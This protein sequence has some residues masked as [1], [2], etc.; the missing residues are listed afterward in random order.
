MTDRDT[1]RENAVEKY[2][3]AIMAVAACMNDLEKRPKQYEYAEWRVSQPEDY[4]EPDHVSYIL[5]GWKNA[6]QL[7]EP[8]GVSREIVIQEVA[9]LAERAGRI[10]S[11]VEWDR[12]GVFPK[13]ETVDHLFTSWDEVAL[14]AAERVNGVEWDTSKKPTP[15]AEE[16]GR[17][18]GEPRETTTSHGGGLQWT[19]I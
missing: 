18:G 15:P 19:T 12:Y 10:P 1:L 11:R 5:D 16:N 2:E 13:L 17:E 14:E 6:K 7:A 3:Q 4:P 8:E 9:D